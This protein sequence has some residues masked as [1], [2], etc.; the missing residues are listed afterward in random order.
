[1]KNYKNVSLADMFKIPKNSFKKSGYD[2]L[3]WYLKNNENKW[4]CYDNADHNKSSWKEKKQCVYGH[5]I[6]ND[7]AFLNIPS[8]DYSSV[9]LVA[10]W[11]KVYK[12]KFDGNGATSGSMETVSLNSRNCNM[13][14]NNKFYKEGYAFKGWY[15]KRADG[16]ELCKKSSSND[17]ES[18]WLDKT[19]CNR[20]G[21]ELI[22]QYLF[23]DFCNVESDITFVAQWTKNFFVDFFANG[24]NGHMDTQE[25]PYGTPTSLKA[26]AFK[27]K[28]H[29]F[30]G[31]NA[32][33]NDLKWYCYTNT[34]PNKAEWA[35]EGDCK[36]KYLYKDKL[37]IKD[38]VERGERVTMYAQWEKEEPFTVKYNANGGVGTMSDQ[39]ITY[40]VSTAMSANK[41]TKSGYDFKGWYANRDDGTWYCY[42]NPGQGSPSWVGK[43]TCESFGYFLYKDQLKLSNT[44]KPGKVVTMYAQWKTKQFTLRFDAAGGTGSM[45]D[46]KI[47]YGT[48]TPIT[49]NS[50]KK[51][52]YNFNGWKAQR[53][54]NKWYCYSSPSKTSTGWADRSVCD[55]NGYYIYKDELKVKD[56][57]NIGGYT[58]MHATW[59]ENKY[60]VV[61]D[62]NGGVGSMSDQRMTYGTPTAMNANKFTRSG[63]DFKGWYAQRDDNKWYCYTD[64]TKTK[65]DWVNKSTCG[66]YGYYL[67]KDK[68]KLSDTAKPGG[69]V[70]MY[71]QWAI[72]YFT[73][74]YNANG[75]AGSMSYQNITYGVSTAMNA[76][77]FTKTGYDF[78][79]WHANYLDGTWY[80]YTDL[81][82]TKRDW[83]NQSTCEKYGY[84][85]YKDKLKISDTAPK[86]GIV[87]MYAQWQR[88]Q[89]TLKFDANGG[90]GS[91]SDQKII[92]GTPTPITKNSFKKE[93]YNFN[94]WKAQRDD[95]K[96][97]CYSSPS[98]TSTGWADRSVCDTNGYYIYKDELKVKD[99]ANI[100]GYTTMHATWVENKYRVVY[101]ANG[102][103]GSM[104]DQ[105]MTY[106]TPTAMNAN[107]FTRSGYDFKGWYAQRDDNKWY[108]YTDSTK[109]KRDWVN[110]STC[111]TYGYYL[112]KDKLKLSDT[113]KP[114]GAVTMYAQWA[115]NYFTVKYNANG[116]AGSMSYQNITYGVS[117]AMNANKFTK[118]GYDFV[119][120]HANYLDGTWYCYTDLAKTKRDWVNQSTCGS[121]GYYLYKDKLKLSDTAPKGGIVTMYAQWKTNQFTVRYSANGGSGS[122]SDQKITYGVSTS[123]S[124]NKFYKPGYKFVGW[125]AIR[126]DGY[127]YCYTSSSK[128]AS[129]WSSSSTCLGFGHC[130]YKDEQ[131]V[132]KT[133]ARGGLVTMYAQWKKV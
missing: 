29:K 94:G 69:A 8:G 114:G 122:M 15:A 25:I 82:K 17:T 33:R 87:T 132:S 80:C 16:L 19:T 100:G 48:P 79:G 86:G 73:V 92:Y 84:Y 54:D 77:K 85:V 30:I 46:Q 101:D 111:G 56:T 105:R 6:F 18:D 36:K 125:Q 66:T 88:K 20:T 67:Y 97:Y 9:T 107:K 62:A 108:C 93:G 3:G 65:R 72:N 76:N 99:T 78:V 74:K 14:P 59:V 118:T 71:A 95:N 89:F 10:D 21:H 57:A 41:F 119:G 120:W 117:T 26:N 22:F 123:L 23:Y 13:A 128:S 112:Y 110:K 39:K 70:T 40:G 51:E 98:K 58:T 28:D 113:A 129:S 37:K 131:K 133:A 31:W 130:L 106:G 91:M 55:T 61:Y 104:S 42:T 102:G 81:A 12:I 75:G 83:V 63:Y 38:T 103:V 109:T 64:S 115:I 124:K 5:Y 49:K 2:F 34:N 96:W 53:D 52:G 121:Y 32:Q 11:E 27:L 47:T 7:M 116:G 127:H 43:S 126:S 35:F 60:R 68:L 44:A 45:N 90:V 50:F 4:Y 1:M 24:G